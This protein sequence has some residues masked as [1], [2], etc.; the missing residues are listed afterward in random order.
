MRRF[1]VL[2]IIASLVIA[3]H[4]LALTVEDQVSP[5][6]TTSFSGGPWQQQVTVGVSGELVG[7]DVYGVEGGALDFFL[8]VGSGW[9]TDANN[10]TLTTNLTPN[11]WNYIDV[12]SA[13]LMFTAGEQFMIG[14]DSQ[15]GFLVWL[16]GGST[17]N[18]PGIPLYPDPLYESGVP[19]FIT[20]T[21]IAF[22]TYVENSTPVPEPS[23]M[24]LL[25]CGLLGLAGYGR[26]KFFKK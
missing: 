24:L 25:G 1:L 11:G 6:T 20:G 8:N 2:F 14:L 23:T 3:G 4:A 17:V 9:Q 21:R 13:N 26:K 5:Y 10:F 18:P 12:S 16:F 22:K 7:V 15:A 19:W